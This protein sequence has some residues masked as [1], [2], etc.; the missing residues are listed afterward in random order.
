M[1]QRDLPAGIRAGNGRFD[2]AGGKDIPQRLGGGFVGQ[3]AAVSA[4]LAVGCGRTVGCRGQL[5]SNARPI[6]HTDDL[7]RRRYNIQSQHRIYDRFEAVFRP[8]D[9]HQPCHGGKHTA[10]K[11]N[12][13]HSSHFYT[14]F[15]VSSKSAVDKNTR[16]K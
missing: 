5:G 12:R 1:H 3:S 2:A 9:P 11:G 14:P 15:P 6:R 4:D 13:T 16:K 7:H 8:E 10:A